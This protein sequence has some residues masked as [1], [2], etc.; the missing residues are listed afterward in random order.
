MFKIVRAGVSD[1]ILAQQAIREVHGR[2]V[3]DPVARAAFL[4]DSGSYL[5]LAVGDE[6]VV[7]SLVGF[8]LRHPHCAE[9]QFLLYE[10][11]VRPEHRNRGVG[12]ALVS[13]FIA[14]ARAVGAHE[15][16]ALTNESNKAAMRMYAHC[17]FARQHQDD[18]M[19]SANLKES[20]A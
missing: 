5:L 8:A 4:R 9:P 20:P 14:E 6:R 1:D 15:L 10:I 2:P 3:T 7:G 18:V 13:K 12:K 16:W 19:M 17:G 11:D